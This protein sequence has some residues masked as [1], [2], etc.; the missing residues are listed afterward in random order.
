MD[1]RG[2]APGRVGKGK[3]IHLLRMEGDR[4][5]FVMCGARGHKDWGMVVMPGEEI[6]C[7]NCL[8]WARN[9]D[10]VLHLSERL[11]G[12]ARKVQS[13]QAG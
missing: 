5:R 4:P 3:A 2:Y 8:I 1:D 13:G 7:K 12:V 9:N 10:R 11:R 6:T